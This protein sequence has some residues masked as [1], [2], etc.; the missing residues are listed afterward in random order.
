M[1]PGREEP[2]TGSKQ[3]QTNIGSEADLIGGLLWQESTMLQDY[4]EAACIRYI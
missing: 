4:A 2:E 1:V 3:K